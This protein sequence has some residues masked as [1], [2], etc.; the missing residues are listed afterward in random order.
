MKSPRKDFVP[1]ATGTET[2]QNS[3]QNTVLGVAGERPGG[4]V[5]RCDDRNRATDATA[6]MNA[7]AGGSL[8]ERPVWSSPINSNMVHISHLRSSER[9]RA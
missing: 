3:G 2:G 7:I 1:K 8:L 6:P 5:A 9:A 4:C